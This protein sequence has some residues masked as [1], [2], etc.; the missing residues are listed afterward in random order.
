MRDGVIY[1]MLSDN[2]EIKRLEAEVERL[3]QANAAQRESLEIAYDTIA[4]KNLRLLNIRNVL[5][6]DDFFVGSR[7]PSPDNQS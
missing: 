4:G 2:D 3:R 6:A 7:A 1:E 5:E